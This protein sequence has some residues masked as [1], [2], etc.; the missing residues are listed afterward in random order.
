MAQIQNVPHLV[1]DGLSEHSVATH[2]TGPHGVP[3]P[4]Q[5]VEVRDTA[6]VASQDARSVA[7]KNYADFPARRGVVHRPVGSDLF[8]ILY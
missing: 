6:G 2:T 5:R 3:H 7:R 8:D 4:G 1:R